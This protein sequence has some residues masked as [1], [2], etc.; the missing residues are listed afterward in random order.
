MAAHLT[1]SPCGCQLHR[2]WA[3]LHCYILPVAF[4]AIRLLLWADPVHLLF[5]STCTMAFCGWA[6]SS[7]ARR[8]VAHLHLP[9]ALHCAMHRRGL[10]VIHFS[11]RASLSDSSYRLDPSCCLLFSRCYLFPLATAR[12]AAALLTSSE[13][14]AGTS[15]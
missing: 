5:I 11:E 3:Q 14:A 2:C 8:S 1:H 15:L 9:H 7:T 4:S 10:V 6:A 12:P 13:A